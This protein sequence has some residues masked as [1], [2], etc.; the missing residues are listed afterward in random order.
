MLLLLITAAAA[1]G[2]VDRVKDGTPV[3]FTPQA[4]FMGEGDLWDRVQMIEKEFG[5]DDNVLVIMLQGP[6]STPA[7]LKLVHQIH[8]IMAAHPQVEHVDSL[9]TATL[10]IEDGPGMMRVV[11]AIG[12]GDTPLALAAHDRFTGGLLI[13]ADQTVTTIQARIK[14]DV[15]TIADLAPVVRNLESQVRAL[16][17]GPEFEI[18]ITGI[19]FVRTEVVDLMLSDQVR[20]LPI[21]TIIFAFTI[22]V[23]FR[24]LWLGMIPLI[25]VL[26]GVVWAMGALLVG[27][28]VLNILS[29]LTP[30]L[31][32]V[33]G[34][35]DGIHVAARYREELSHDQ[36]RA[37]A[38]GRT[39]RQMSL[40]CFLTTFTTAAGFGSLIVA[41]TR[42]IRDFGTHCASA[43]MVTYFAVILAVPTLLAWLPVHRVGTPTAQKDRR[44]YTFV[45]GIVAKAPGRVLIATLAVTLFAVFLGRN[46]EPNSRLLEMYTPDHPTHEAIKL[47]ETHVGGVIPIFVH[48]S[49]TEDQMLDPVVLRAMD[50]IEQQASAEELTG[51]T[52]SPA[53]WLRQIHHLLTGEDGLPDSRQLA[54]QELLLAEMSGDLAIDKVL[55]DD[56]ARAR[57]LMI[58]RDVGG[59][60]YIRLKAEL[61][62]TANRVLAGTGVQAE[63]SGDGILGS[64]GIN[65]LITDLL[66]SMGLI[67]VV[68]LCT[69]FALLKSVRLALIS[70]LPNLVPLVFIVATLGVMGVDLQTSNIVS[71]TIAVGL[72]VDDTIHFV[73]RYREER[74]RGLALAPAIS[75]TYQ[76]AG[77]AIVITSV[78]LVLGFGVLTFSPLTS[79]RYFGLLAAVTM[80]A[81]VL[82]DLFL[83]PA[84][85]HLFGD[86][87]EPKQPAHHST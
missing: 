52:A 66:K 71:F 85:L 16:N 86:P 12:E 13:S 11:D 9:M 73:V 37:A 31:V 18:H 30:T 19:P 60:E 24:R 58:T 84:M 48:F 5:A 6:L 72:A 67:F 51:W 78:L 39:L 46:V 63:V 49:G 29:M 56:R 79:T 23:M 25:G 35:A 65:K 47:A 50:T 62:D 26:F 80:F 75:R 87:K 22:V 77:H 14:A 41:D 20:F 3:D 53:S 38:M 76:G 82:G 59:R 69:M 10:A 54:A 17:K 83:L 4:I 2:I 21:V 34:A 55:S 7:G 36:D 81:A 15:D 27:G 33:I 64:A 43:V 68:I 44:L 32:L 45:D 28:A 70:T 42:V 74:G 8:E 40:A 57:I 1:V 61:E